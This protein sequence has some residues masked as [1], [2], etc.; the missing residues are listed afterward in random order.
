MLSNSRGS[1]NAFSVAKGRLL[2]NF[3]MYKNLNFCFVVS[4]A[5]LTAYPEPKCVARK[6]IAVKK[7]LYFI[8]INL[9]YT[10]YFHNQ[11]I[12]LP[13]CSHI[14]VIKLSWA[15]VTICSRRRIKIRQV[16]APIWTIGL[17]AANYVV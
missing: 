16:K 8:L 3:T 10:H 6:K 17:L 9:M 11:S 13:T 14:S 15:F 12:L 1:I 7:T 5:K 2:L 4:L